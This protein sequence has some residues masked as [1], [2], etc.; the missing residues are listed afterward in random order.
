MTKVFMGQESSTLFVN[1]L[2]YLEQH[3]SV[4]VS[5]SFS[6]FSNY[7]NVN[8][9]S[10]IKNM[11][12]KETLTSTWT[13]KYSPCD[14]VCEEL[15]QVSIWRWMWRDPGNG[16]AIAGVML[17]PPFCFSQWSSVS[18]AVFP[19]T[20]PFTPAFYIVWLHNE[21]LC[22]RGKPQVVSKRLCS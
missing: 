6:S 19:I 17:L 12:T 5:Y 21:S 8:V 11:K 1:C 4:S 14:S 2:P 22:S 20:P 9:L 13:R 18:Q 10:I 15:E 7:V 16:W 3:L